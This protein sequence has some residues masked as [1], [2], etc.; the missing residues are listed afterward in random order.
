M[1]SSLANPVPADAIFNRLVHD[2]KNELDW[3]EWQPFR[4][5]ENNSDVPQ[6]LGVYQVRACSERGRPMPIPR[7]CGVDESGLLYVGEGRLDVRL[8]H[9]WYLCQP[10]SKFHHHFIRTFEEHGLSRI[11]NRVLSEVRWTVTDDC[12][13]LER[14]LIAD[15]CKQFGD[16]PPGNLKLGG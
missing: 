9:L 16:L 12:K 6:K 1:P 15:Y 2:V 14:D 4:E 7:C 5:W 8:G 10:K 11:A 13:Q 3:K